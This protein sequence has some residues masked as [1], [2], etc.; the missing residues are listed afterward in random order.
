MRGRRLAHVLHPG[1]AALLLAVSMPAPV[2]EAA[3]PDAVPVQCTVILASG[4]TDTFDCSRQDTDALF[5]SVPAALYLHVT[6]LLIVRNSLATTGNYY[7]T[8]GRESG[9]ILP[10]NPSITTS[11]TP[12][13]PTVL[14][15]K[16]PV[17]VLDPGEALAA[18]NDGSSDFSINIYASGY[19]TD[20]PSL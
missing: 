15:F 9:G 12:L 3:P 10:S 16:T 20:G 4:S 1:A 14:H 17:V 11:G 6:D 7:A 19:L 13:S 8:I 5:V 18:R 2:A